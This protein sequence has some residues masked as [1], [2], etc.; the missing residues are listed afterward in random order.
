MHL[1][2]RSEYVKFRVLITGQ[3]VL[4]CHLKK[5]D[6]DHVI[7]CQSNPFPSVLPFLS[8]SQEYLTEGPVQ[9]GDPAGLFSWGLWWVF[10]FVLFWSGLG[11]FLSYD[12]PRTFPEDLLPERWH[13]SLHP[14]E[15]SVV[16][17][18]T[19][20]HVGL[21]YTLDT[22]LRCFSRR[23]DIHCSKI[24]TVPG[25]VATDLFARLGSKWL[26]W[27][28]HCSEHYISA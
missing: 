21:I 23:W 13:L 14:V 24:S 26:H 15:K 28:S 27:C 25:V 18:T 6:L 5:W 16:N 20:V 8:P 10:C 2:T 9:Q 7:L 12:T 3:V 1:N 4:A 19:L 22:D 17:Q 11:F